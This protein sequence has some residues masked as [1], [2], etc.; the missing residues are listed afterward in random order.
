M[1]KKEK[2]KVTIYVAIQIPVYKRSRM[3]MIKDAEAEIDYLLS[4]VVSPD[5]IEYSI[6][7]EKL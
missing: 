6:L 3:E 2:E 5:G 1:F 4:G 7:G